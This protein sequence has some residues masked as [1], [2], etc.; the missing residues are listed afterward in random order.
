M[1]LLLYLALYTTYLVYPDLVIV[2]YYFVASLSS[3][4]LS[5]KEI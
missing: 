5:C 3:E 1:D 4:G 2:L